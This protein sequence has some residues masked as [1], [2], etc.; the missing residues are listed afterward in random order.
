[1]LRRFRCVQ[2]FLFKTRTEGLDTDSQ[3]WVITKKTQFGWSLVDNTLVITSININ[4]FF[5]EKEA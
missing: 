4:N 5:D 1:M 2:T 3:E